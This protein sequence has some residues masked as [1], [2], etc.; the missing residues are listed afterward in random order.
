GADLLCL[1]ELDQKLWVALACPVRGLEF[2]VRTLELLDTDG[3]GRIRAPEVLAAVR[4]AGAVLKNPDD[5][6]RGAAA[7][8]LAALDDG[9]PEARVLLASARQVL[10]DL[11]KAAA[12]EITL[13]DVGDT[14][15]I[16]AQT[17]F[18]GDGV[19]PADAAEAKEV[20]AV[21][22]DVIACLG[23]DP[24]RSGKPGVTRERVDR[25]FAEAR[26]YA[27]WRQRAE[28]EPGVL[29]LGTATAAAHGA[30]EAVRAKVHDYFIRCR[31]S[32]FDPRAAGP[33]NRAEADYVAL[34]A[35]D[36]SA[37]QD[38]VAAFPLARVEAGRPLPLGD[39]VNPAWAGAMAALRDK[40]VEPLLGPRDALTAEEWQQ[41]V[42]RFSAHRDWLGAK[43]GAA[44]EGLGAARVR[45]ILAG[46]GRGQIETLITQDEALRP[47]AESIAAVERLIRYHRDLH[48]LLNNFVSFRDFYTGRAKAVFQAGTLYLD[49]RSCEL[50]VRV[51]DPA[52]HGAL[53]AL[54]KAYLVYCD[55]TRRGA[56]AEKMT[57]AAA[58]TGGDSDFLMVGRNGVFYDRQ[59]RDWDA[60]IVKV[61]E[62]PISI[63]QAFWSP[64]KRAARMVG[65]QVEKFAASRDKAVQDQ[66][67]AAAAQTG[68]K[69]EAAKAAIPQAFD[70]G[71]FVGIFAA[72]GLALG[73][74]GSALA[75]VV[76]GLLGLGWWQMPLALAG[77]VL[78]VSGP[79]ML[80]AAL[81]L[82]QRNLGPILDANGWAVNARA[83]INIPFGGALTGVAALPAG[84][85]RSYT[86]PYA[87][88]KTPWGLYLVLVLLAGAVVWLWRAGYLARWLG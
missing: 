35:K 36:L 10:A 43:V 1:G 49:G 71:K 7:L 17:R 18:N 5:L 79:S 38:E 73:A 74:I 51:D 56:A 67:A 16:F 30:L 61:V 44:V 58:F 64:Y 27:E 55:C 32:A 24:D 82:R 11:G 81:K 46:T 83:M 53:A 15:R 77:A 31:L 3:D 75:V 62:N 86:D 72:I 14:A 66:A 68:Q 37:A 78:A 47:Q 20:R 85:E 50:C 21:I 22:E 45:E 80:L 48:T 12:E 23:S 34:A 28:A 42:G 87:Q 26:A 69:P 39:G 54:S 59:G 6:T 70:L 8:P 19:V 4:W 76:T 2:D 60:T 65:E 13:E 9:N 57:V 88:K 29:P 33:L 40:V 84:A 52:K 41:L 63:R 25:F